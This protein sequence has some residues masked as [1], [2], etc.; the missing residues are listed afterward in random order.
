VL[1][2]ASGAHKATI[3]RD[4]IEGPETAGVPASW[5]R[6]HGDLTWLLDEAAASRL[7]RE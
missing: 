2:L 7:S 3:V 4:A 6:E 1:V 5:L